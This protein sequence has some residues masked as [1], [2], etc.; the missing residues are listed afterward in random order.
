[1]QHAQAIALRS[2]LESAQVAALA[3]LHKGQPA[4]SMVPYALLPQGQG[5]V[6]H[7]S[8]LATHTADMMAHANV[9]L[10]VVAPPASAPAA[11]EL[12][13]ASIQARVQ[14][15]SPG[16]N[17]HALASQCYLA[18]FPESADTFGFSDFSLLRLAVQSVRFV[19][20]FANTSSIMA[21]RFEAIMSDPGEPGAD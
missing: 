20:G 9:A 10:L 11:R 12:A 15:I 16:S 4:A 7:V 5:F 6:I 3:T 13:R 8:R 18:R 14:T 21:A 2:L 19:G 17:N 1:M